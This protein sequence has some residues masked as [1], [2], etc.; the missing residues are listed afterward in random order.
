MNT[1]E[2]K[3]YVMERMSEP[4]TWRGLVLIATGVFGWTLPAGVTIEQVVSIGLTM[5]GLIG[6]ATKDKRTAQAE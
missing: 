1:Q 3:N 4:S 2:L 5:A 6:A